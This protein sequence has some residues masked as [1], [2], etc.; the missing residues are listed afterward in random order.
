MA[1][2]Q[3]EPNRGEQADTSRTVA[4]L[5]LLLWLTVVMVSHTG[6]RSRSASREAAVLNA[7]SNAISH[8]DVPLHTSV[9]PPSA[10][11]LRRFNA[12]RGHF[13][14]M[15]YSQ[16]RFHEVEIPLVFRGA[17]PYVRALWSGRQI[18][19]LVDTGTG[20]ILWPQW[21]RLDTE[22]ETVIQVSEGTMENPDA[23]TPWNTVVPD[24]KGGFNLAVLPLP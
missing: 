16:R 20:V 17:Y 14:P 22:R 5:I 12:V 23:G 8:R 3:R 7:T 13:R 4:R 19:C 24:D 15:L 11:A 9:S 21:L 6:C 1:N 2:T 18:D 10:D